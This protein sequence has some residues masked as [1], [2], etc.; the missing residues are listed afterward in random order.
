MGCTLHQ[1][2]HGHAHGGGS[3]G[4]HGHAHGENINVRA[5]FIHVLGDFLQSVGVFIA[6]L[7]IYFVPNVEIIDPICTFVFSVL[8]LLTTV[9]ILRDTMNVLMEGIPRDVSFNVVQETFLSVEGIVAVHNLRIWGLT[10]D[11]TALAAHLAVAPGSNA[12]TIL[13]EASTRIRAQY[14]FYEMTLQVEEFE[15]N[16]DDCTQCKPPVS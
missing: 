4:G 8:V 10:T 15:D 12:Q 14:N 3:S 6:A 7:I 13:R 16:M 1:H 9:R 11:K 2:G 5:A